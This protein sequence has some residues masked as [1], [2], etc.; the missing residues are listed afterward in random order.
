MISRI[1]KPR[2]APTKQCGMSLVEVMVAITVGLILV[3]GLV[4]FFVGNK[5]SYQ[6][7]ESINGLQENGRYA[8]RI[9]SESMHIADHWGGVEGK[10]IRS[11]N[12]PVVGKGSCDGAWVLNASEGLMGFDGAAASPLPAGCVSNANYLPNTDAFVV[13]HAGGEYF[14]GATANASG[15]AIWLNST[16][17]ANAVIT[18]GTAVNPVDAL[19]V[20]HYPY[21]VSA[22]YIRPC[23]NPQPAGADC[24]AADDG[25]NPIPTL[26]RLNLVD[27][28]LEEQSLVSGVE[29]MQLEYGVDTNG[30]G[31]TDFYGNATQL[32]ASQWKNVASIRVGLVFRTDKRGSMVDTTTYSLPGGFSYVPSANDQMFA[33][34]M[35]TRVIQIRNRSRS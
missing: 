13:R 25:G 26:V 11:T 10:L 23:S 4:Q 32:T 27:N 33:R 30:D 5:R 28:V 18:D 8:M 35:F 1:C 3:A 20:Y 17:G 29:Q 24:T 2:T 7:L 21:K 14:N 31:N 9:I 15:N 22:Y 6:V 19:G 34:K 16:V 12:P